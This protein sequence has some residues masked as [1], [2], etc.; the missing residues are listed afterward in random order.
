MPNNLLP[1]LSFVLITTFTLGLNNISSALMGVLHGYKKTLAYL[2]GI[3][4]GFFLMMLLSG[5]VSMSLLSTFP[6]FE[7]GLHWVG[8]GYILYLAFGTL[9][10]SY[11]FTEGDA[12]PMGFGKGFMLQLLNPK[13]IVYGLTLFSAFLA[14]ITDNGA[15]LMLA[16]ILLTVT[17]F[18]SISTW[19][20]FGTAIKTHLHQPRIKAAVN[21]VLSLFLVYT[22]V[23]LLPLSY[24]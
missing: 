5:W 13:L 15:L 20:L 21:I 12:K 6:A 9:K 1:L 18:C 11:S 19:A 3:A 14:P 23:E 16:V 17:A 22:A 10:A 4:T 24:Y 8:A 2:G 7:P